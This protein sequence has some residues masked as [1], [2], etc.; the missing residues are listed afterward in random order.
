MEDGCSE[1]PLESASPLPYSFCRVLPPSFTF[2]G[3]S[4]KAQGK[5]EADLP[6]TPRME[7]RAATDEL[8]ETGKWP[9]LPSAPP[10]YCLGP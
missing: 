8:L 7:E 4:H 1:G 6:G 9:E 5:P 2:P 3:S 10:R